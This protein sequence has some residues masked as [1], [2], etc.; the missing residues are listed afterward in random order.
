MTFRKEGCRLRGPLRRV[1]QGWGKNNSTGREVDLQNIINI[2]RHPKIMMFMMLSGKT[3]IHTRKKNRDFFFHIYI[4]FREKTSETSS[5]TGGAACHDIYD[6]LPSN[7]I[8]T[9]YQNGFWSKSDQSEPETRTTGIE[10]TARRWT[11]LTLAPP[12]SMI[13][14]SDNPG[15][16]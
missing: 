3:L 1:D 7:P 12:T 11:R 14:K 13:G 16:G 8:R 6:V 9:P 2:I 5:T 15:V 10:P 4:G